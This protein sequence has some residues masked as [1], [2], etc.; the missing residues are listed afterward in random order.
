M[1]IVR[2][3][4]QSLAIQTDTWIEWRAVGAGDD[5]R[6]FF[7][8]LAESYLKQPF[9]VLESREVMSILSLH[10]NKDV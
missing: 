4:L 7:V 3:D 2:N 9:Y 8:R 6:L 5:R 1:P 10:V